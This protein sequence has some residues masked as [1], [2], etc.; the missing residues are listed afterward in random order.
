MKKVTLDSNIFLRLL[1]KDNQKLLKKSEKIFGDIYDEKIIGFV[2]IL[3]VNEILWVLKTYYKLKREECVP[4]VKQLVSLKNVKLIEVKK[5][6]V[7]N[8]LDLYEKT[9]FDFTDI[10]LS[11]ITQQKDLVSFD[12]DFEKLYKILS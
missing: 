8:V 7:L 6:V 3:V 10:Y 5:D 2:S 4:G 11:K 1:V 9:N 12:K